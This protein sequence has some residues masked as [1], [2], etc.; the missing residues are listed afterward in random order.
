MS[1]IHSIRRIFQNRHLPIVLGMIAGFLVLYPY[2]IVV[3]SVMHM[4]QLTNLHL[5]IAELKKQLGN[6]LTPTMLPM[7][8]SF[9]LFGG[10]VGM[11]VGWLMERKK[12]LLQ[13]QYEHEKQK[14]ALDTVKQLMVTLSHHLLNSNMIIG[15]KV[16]RLSK[17]SQ[18]NELLKDLE[19]IEQQG[20]RIDSVVRALRDAT[21]LKIADYS[22]GGVVK[23]I[24]IE[25]EI[26]DRLDDKGDYI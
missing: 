6:M 13:I 20:R 3:Y 24:D 11:L 25:R 16:R 21:E 14:V 26:E 23:M 17:Y 15:G 8:L 7:S 22:S 10:F 9:I 4:H 5:H 2:T 18:N 12:A 1:D 19:V